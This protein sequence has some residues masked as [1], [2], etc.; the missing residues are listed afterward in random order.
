[1]WYQTVEDTPTLFSATLE[2]YKDFSTIATLCMRKRYG[3]SIHRLSQVEIH[4][5][6]ENISLSELKYGPP[7]S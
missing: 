4:E 6:D 1:M 2:L 7:N 3:I 5:A